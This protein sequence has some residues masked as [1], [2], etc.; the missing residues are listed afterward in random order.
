MIV[1]NIP[2]IARLKGVQHPVTFLVKHGFSYHTAKKL[3]AGNMQ[4]IDLRHMDKLCRIFLCVPNDLL[5]YRPPKDQLKDAPDHLAFLTKEAV[6]EDI[7]AILTKLS[8]SETEALL[9]ETRRRG[10]SS[11]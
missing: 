9:K 6:P 7:H 2:R 1:L 8:L 3:V 5:D 4:R 10:G 11:S